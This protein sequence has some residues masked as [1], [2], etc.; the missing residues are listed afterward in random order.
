MSVPKTKKLSANEGVRKRE[1][2]IANFIGG[3]AWGLGSVIGATIIVAILVWV[4]NILGLFDF[5]KDYFPRSSY[6]NVQINR[7]N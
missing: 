5:V 7:D 4:L 2:L 6:S 1:V 3:I